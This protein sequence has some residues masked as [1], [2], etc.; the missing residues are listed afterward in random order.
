[1][2]QTAA[3]IRI[4]QPHHTARPSESVHGGPPKEQRR[5]LG[6]FERGVSSG[7]P[8]FHAPSRRMIA[9]THVPI[10]EFA[11]LRGF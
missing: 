2:L 5:G 4:P 10:E 11:T 8:L 3:S 1:M 6:S 9:A 7:E